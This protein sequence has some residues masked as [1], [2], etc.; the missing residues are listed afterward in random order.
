[1]IQS[2]KFILAALALHIT[3]SGSAFAAEEIGKAVAITVSVT[4]DGGPLRVSSPIHRD[5]RIKTS[6]SGTGQFLFRDG[7]K[8]AVGPNSSLVLDRSVFVGSSAFKTLSL[9]ATRGTF[10]WI[11]GKSGSSAYKIST[12]FGTLGIRGTAVDFYIGAGTA[13]VIILEGRAVFCGNNGVCKLLNRG[14]DMVTANR[15]GVIGESK[16]PAKTAVA[17]VRNDVSFPFLVGTR[18]LSQ[19]FRVGGGKCGLSATVRVIDEKTGGGGGG[20]GS[21]GSNDN[22]P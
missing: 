2:T 5:E 15:N 17:G 3:L 13:S 1:M 18:K 7:T 11:S 16:K 22:G 20:G 10:R 4:G 9:K 12:P 14:C 19:P 6:S 21:G 8:L